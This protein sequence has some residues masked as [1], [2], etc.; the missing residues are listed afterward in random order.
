ML[1]I[2]KLKTKKIKYSVAL[3]AIAFALALPMVNNYS[4]ASVE[5]SFDLTRFL[6]FNAYELS[7]SRAPKTSG[8]YNLTGSNIIVDDADPNYNWSKTAAENDWCS[9]MGT[10]EDPYIIEN[11]YIDGGGSIAETP[12]KQHSGNC[13]SIYRSTAYFIVRG[14]YFTQAGTGEFNS[15]IYLAYTEN[16]ILYNNTVTNSFNNIFV[17]DLSHNT[18][19]LYNVMSHDEAHP[20]RACAIQFSDDCLLTKNLIANGY[21]G[22]QLINSKNVELRQNLLNSSIYG[23][24]VSVGIN[25]IFIN[26]SKITYNVFAGDYTGTNFEVLQ[27]LSSGNVIENNTISGTIPNLGVPTPQL[28][29]DY[30]SLISLANSYSNTVAHNIAYLPGYITPGIP[31]YDAFVV[32]GSIGL[33]SALLVAAATIKRKTKKI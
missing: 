10:I 20:G 12:G 18:T 9:G 30:T 15:G 33:V 25:L 19:V 28:S 1:P 32:L 16:G 17:N 3:L 24:P 6:G 13:L 14:C 4:T 21:T 7:S 2:K 8:Y 22:F 23:V 5:E 11:V 31:G 27:S 26:D 29:S